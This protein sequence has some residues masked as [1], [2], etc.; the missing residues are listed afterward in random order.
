MKRGHK[1]PHKF[2][3]SFNDLSMGTARRY[4]VTLLKFNVREIFA[5]ILD[6]TSYVRWIN[7]L[8]IL[9]VRWKEIATANASA[10]Q[11]YAQTT[12]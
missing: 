1:Q 9:E 7:I 6:V 2:C 8:V 4:Y 12:L 10:A 11:D 5:I 3:N